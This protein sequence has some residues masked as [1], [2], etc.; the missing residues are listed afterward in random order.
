M[1]GCI[2][3]AGTLPGSGIR[4]PGVYIRLDWG[5]SMTQVGMGAHRIYASHAT[6]KVPK[7]LSIHNDFTT[8]LPRY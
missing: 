1:G 6:C 8:Y 4:P 5:I 2:K 3:W 7:K